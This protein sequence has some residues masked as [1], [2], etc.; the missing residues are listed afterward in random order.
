KLLTCSGAALPFSSTVIGPL[1][2]SI[3]I[4]TVAGTLVA[5]GGGGRSACLI[6]AWTS[7]GV[8]CACLSMS[9]NGCGNFGSSLGTTRYDFGSPALVVVVSSVATAVCVV[10]PA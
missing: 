8:T 3:R 1:D 5:A 4:F 2:V 7:S 6:A 9:T 10:F